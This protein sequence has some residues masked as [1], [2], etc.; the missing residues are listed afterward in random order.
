MM[1]E[2][3]GFRADYP[4]LLRILGTTTIGTPHNHIQRLSGIYPDLHLVYELG[5]LEDIVSYINQGYPV[6]IFVDTR[7]LPYWYGS[8]GHAVVVFG[9]S[10]DSFYL[11]DPE[12]SDTP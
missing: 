4:R 12:F 8:F 7:D 3:A 6:G 9:Y 5:E 10:D 11:N 1:L 2:F